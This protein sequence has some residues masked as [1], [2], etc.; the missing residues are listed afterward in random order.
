MLL[1]I[2]SFNSVTKIIELL[3]SRSLASFKLN[4]KQIFNELEHKDSNRLE[5]KTEAGIILD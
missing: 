5:V 1:W 4:V 3:A 2:V